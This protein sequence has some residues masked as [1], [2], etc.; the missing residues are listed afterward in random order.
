MNWS[1]TCTDDSLSGI[2]GGVLGGLIVIILIAVVAT[3]I[4]IVGKKQLRSKQVGQ[5]PSGEPHGLH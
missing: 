1:L 3:T 4:V 5:V 2:L